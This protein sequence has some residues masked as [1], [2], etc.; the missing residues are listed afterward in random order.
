MPRLVRWESEARD[1][2]GDGVV[3][4]DLGR[5]VPVVSVWAVADVSSGDAAIAPG[6]ETSPRL[7]SPAADLLGTTANGVATFADRRSYLELLIVRPGQGAWTLSTGD[8]AAGD[9]DGAPDGVIVPAIAQLHAVGLGSG[10]PAALL[11]GDTVAAIDPSTFEYYT[12]RLG[13]AK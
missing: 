5:D 8:G 11:P 10:R 7:S 9:D 12:V 6:P 13:R 1:D 3:A 4:F 2:D